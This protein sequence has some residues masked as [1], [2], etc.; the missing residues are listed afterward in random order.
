MATNATIESP[1]F[2]KIDKEAGGFTSNAIATLWAALNDTRATERRD[3][4]RASNNVSPGLLTLAPAGSTDNLDITNF[5]IISFTGASAQNFTGMR[6]P[7]TG[8]AKI[9][10][11]QVSGAGTITFKHNVTSET[12]NQLTNA[13]G[14]DVARTTGQGIIYAYLASK[15][16]EIA[17]SA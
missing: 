7:E 12:A 11:C 15:W 10:F 2:E 13:S 16:R 6:A 5:G 8:D 9:M 3:F 14:A 4:R 1:N 17:R